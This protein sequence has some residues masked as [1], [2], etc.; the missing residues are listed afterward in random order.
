M[1]YWKY[2]EDYCGL[3]FSLCSC[4]FFLVYYFFF[5]EP[6]LWDPS[7]THENC[8]AAFFPTIYGQNQGNEFR[9]VP[10]GTAGIFHTGSFASTETHQ[11]CSEKNTSN[12]GVVLGIPGKIPDFGQLIDTGPILTCNPKMDS[13]LMHSPSLF[14]LKPTASLNLEWW[15][16]VTQATKWIQN[17]N[18][19]TERDEI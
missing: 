4:F 10:A 13:S 16:T 11:F 3:W 17:Q 1:F 6:F 12:T 8:L 5:I 18:Y 2:I 19:K 15:W 9:T 7:V 14:S